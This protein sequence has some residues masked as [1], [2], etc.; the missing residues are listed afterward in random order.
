MLFVYEGFEKD[1]PSRFR[2]SQEFLGF[3]LVGR[4]PGLW[5]HAICLSGVCEIMRFSEET[6]ERERVRST[7]S[8]CVVWSRYLP[9]RAD[10]EVDG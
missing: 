3:C 2:P 4:D 1:R 7:S 8:K 6:E 9:Q 5:C 10:H